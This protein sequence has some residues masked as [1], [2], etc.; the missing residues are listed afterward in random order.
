MSKYNLA[1]VIESLCNQSLILVRDLTHLQQ[2]K[3][4][5]LRQLKKYI[6]LI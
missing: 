1:E 4:C 5:Y 6:G 2:A 3:Y